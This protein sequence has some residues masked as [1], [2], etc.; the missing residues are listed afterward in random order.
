MS[1]AKKQWIYLAGF[2]DGDGSIYVRVKPNKSYRF[3][4]QI[5][6][7]IAFFQSAKVESKIIEIQK[8]YE[9]GYLRKRN[10]GIIEWVI[11]REEEIRIIVKNTI[12]FL[13]LKKKQAELM[14][15][16]LD[17]KSKLETKK[18]FISLAKKIDLFRKLNYSKKRKKRIY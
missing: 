7:T 13:R 10:D 18:D 2:L 14:I 11:G 9:L 8:D 15:E 4:F 1:L 12:S 17:R 3:G 5:A 6:P 16:V